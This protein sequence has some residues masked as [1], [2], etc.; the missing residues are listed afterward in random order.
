[1]TA[2]GKLFRLRAVLHHLEES[3]SDIYVRQCTVA[4]P[5]AAFLPDGYANRD[6]A[7]RVASFLKKII[8]V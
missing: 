7:L 6:I 1:M 3:L 8:Q 4:I 2:H 5:A